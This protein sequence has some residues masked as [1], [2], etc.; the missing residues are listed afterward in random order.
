MIYGNI[1]E[2]VFIERLN[3]FV[4]LIEIWGAE[5]KCHVRNTGRLKELLVPGARVW[6][7]RSFDPERK[8]KYDLITVQN[9]ERLVN[10]DSGAPNKVFAELALEGGFLPDISILR[11]EQTYGDSR[12]DF[13]AE[14][15]GRRAFIEIKG[16][17]LLD[18]EAARFPDAPTLRGI[19]HLEGLGDCVGE[20]FEAYIVFIV[21]MKGA[22]YFAPDEKTHPEFAGALRRAAERGVVVRAFDCDVSENAI[23]ASKELEVRIQEA[24]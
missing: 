2:A 22:K 4:A 13:Y 18:G 6:V 23:F 8:T 16:V 7:Q 24:G 17:T 10:V 20:G 14:H 1:A 19:K 11:A 5:E 12:F 9:G 3:R 21:A 15:S